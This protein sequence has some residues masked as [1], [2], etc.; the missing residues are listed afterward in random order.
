MPKRFCISLNLLQSYKLLPKQHTS[1][2]I[3]TLSTHN[4]NTPIISESTKLN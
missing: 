1:S 4:I 2:Y 3:N